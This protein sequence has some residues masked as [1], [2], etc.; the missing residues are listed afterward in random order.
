MRRRAVR[1]DPRRSMTDLAPI[2]GVLGAAVGVVDTIPYVRDTVYGSTRP[3]RWTWLIWGVLA[4]VACISQ[5]ADG[6]SW[7]ILMAATQAVLTGLVFL[8]AIR[9][10]EGGMSWID[11]SLIAVACA[12]VVGWMVADEPLVAVGCVIVA[13][14]SA[15]AMMTPKA[16]RD[17]GSETLTMYALAGVGGALA[18]GAVGELDVSLLLY[19]AYYC[20]VNIALALLIY[21]R[22]R[23]TSWS[24]PRCAR[25]GGRRASLAVSDAKGST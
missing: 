25:A 17:P 11:V 13:D 3:H 21:A 2:L 8:V 15:A 24:P 14:L 6:A 22:R 20:A 23:R 5:R 16:Y 10:G 12:G 1:D 19:P 18:A 4:V 9:H 7:S